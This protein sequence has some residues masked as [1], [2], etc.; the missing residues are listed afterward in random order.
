[1]VVSI[2]NIF[3]LNVSFSFDM[4]ISTTL[5]DTQLLLHRVENNVFQNLDE[6]NLGILPKLQL[7]ILV[8]DFP[9]Y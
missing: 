4:I 7:W 6:G 5:K 3:G 9:R 8:V 2:I 1:M